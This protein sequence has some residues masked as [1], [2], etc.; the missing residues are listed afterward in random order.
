MQ[1][2][3]DR[4]MLKTC[5]NGRPG[6]FLCILFAENAMCYPPMP[7][8]CL[9][10]ESCLGQNHLTIK[11]VWVI[12]SLHLFPGFLYGSIE[13]LVFGMPLEHLDLLCRDGCFLFS[14]DFSTGLIT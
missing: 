2:N 1:T 9:R 14:S 13:Q 7:V 5:S 10:S 11:S 12:N 6:R 8:L 4:V 3:L